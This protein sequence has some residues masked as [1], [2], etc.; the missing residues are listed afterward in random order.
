[1]T[2]STA[3]AG[4]RRVCVV[5]RV[6]VL[7]VLSRA[8]LC[9][10]LLAA[11][12]FAWVVAM[13]SSPSSSVA[14]TAVSVSVSVRTV[15]SVSVMPASAPG[16]GHAL[17]VGAAPGGGGKPAAPKSAASKSSGGS[18]G[19]GKA[20]PAASK[21][22]AKA[23]AAKAAPKPAA[24]APAAKAPAAKAPAPKAPA[25]AA[26]APAPKTPVP[27]AKTP[28]PKAPVSVAKT[29]QST[30]PAGKTPPPGGQH[31][32]T[33]Q[34]A[35]ATK[36]SDTGQANT[37]TSQ[38][39]KSGQSTKTPLPADTSTGKTGQAKNSDPQG[40]VPGR[41]AHSTADQ[42]APATPAFHLSQTPPSAL[43]QLGRPSGKMPGGLTAT[44][45]RSGKPVFG[46]GT[47]GTPGWTPLPGQPD[48]TPP[49]SSG[50]GGPGNA[51]NG[52]PGSGGPGT[53][54][55]A[56][57]ATPQQGPAATVGLASQRYSDSNHVQQP[58]NPGKTG[59][60]TRGDPTQHSDNN[61]QPTPAAQAGQPV[62]PG[63]DGLNDSP[64]PDPHTP[65]NGIPDYSAVHCTAGSNSCYG[66][67]KLGDHYPFTR[68]NPQVPA[69]IA[70]QTHQ[71]DL[72]SGNFSRNQNNLP[73][74]ALGQ[75]SAPGTFQGIN[76][77]LGSSSLVAGRQHIRD[78]AQ[79]NY[80]RAT[81][82]NKA[83]ARALLDRTQRALDTATKQHDNAQ[84]RL[85]PAIGNGLLGA[86]SSIGSGL[87]G[88]AQDAAQALDTTT[89]RSILGK[90]KDLAG[91]AANK[92]KKLFTKDD[93]AKPGAR[94][95]TGSSGV[96]FEDPKHPRLGSDGKYHIREGQDTDTPIDDPAVPGRTITDIDRVQGGVLWEEKTA[97]NAG[98]ING[99]VEKHV[100]K[101][102]RSYIEARPH[103][104]GYE[105][106]PV[107]IDFARPG[108][109]P[110]LRSAVE[111]AIN[112]LRAQNPGVDIRV[113][114]AK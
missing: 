87:K 25:P 62:P 46:Y 79:A 3:S 10:A 92:I 104:A 113:K 67:D 15:A 86:L 32:A 96:R 81:P 71:L 20:K 65:Q 99:W 111:N 7:S 64:F 73:S 28:A 9:S 98:N 74:R 63:N 109:S 94:T 114:W 105:K 102:L 91:T 26:K 76:D 110:Q 51:N 53:G 108:T 101:K 6:V 103:I 2:V 82:E 23:P 107:G 22:A 8:G 68:D 54:S 77:E 12:G 21:P 44:F 85:L 84:S 49:A 55:N 52:D 14:P 19:G 75:T 16:V 58:V 41:S 33:G 45:D 78:L 90:A 29:P 69:R 11:V 83:G 89:G 95:D 47:P 56:D 17:T 42:N 37:V 93:K 61:P 100:T 27:A 34:P 4:A 80:D 13:L 88:L 36:R 40:A 30:P 18:S 43:S 60:P 72:A 31:P 38:P 39:D 24:K 57:S 48:S 106:A 112:Q 59:K 1:M 70:W 50:S 35:T 66:Q 5:V 97:I